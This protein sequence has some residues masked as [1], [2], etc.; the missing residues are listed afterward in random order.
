M[1]IAISTSSFAVF[2]RTPLD[3]L[4]E[5]SID[6]VLNNTGRVLTEAE[7]MELLQGCTGIIAGTEPLSAK[8]MDNI[9]SLQV[10]SRLGVGLDGVDLEAAKERNIAVFTTPHAPS[11][12]VAEL[13]LGL[14]LTLLRNIVKHH[15]IIQSGQWQK[16]GG[17]LLQGK[18][19]GI[20]G[21]GCIG[22]KVANLFE[23]FGA[24]IAYYDVQRKKCKFT[25]MPLDEILSWAQIVSLHCPLDSQ[26]APLLGRDELSL[27]QEAWVINTARGGLV[28]EQALYENIQNG[29][30]LGAALDVFEVEPYLGVLRELDNVILSPHSASFAKEA[31]IAMEMEATHNL[32]NALGLTCR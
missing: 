18:K 32:L 20:I 4:K 29:R 25:Y 8:V 10:I 9:G 31:R 7:V 2:D 17:F 15:N 6:I 12:A 22:L 5:N 11:Q 16:H 13:T 21:L 19:V 24:N 1:K 28:D 27:M 30:I 3:L 14:S 26:N 23:A